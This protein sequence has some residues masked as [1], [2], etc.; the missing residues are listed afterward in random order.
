MSPAKRPPDDD[1]ALGALRELFAETDRAVA[2]LTC[3]ASTE[4]CRFGVTG[5]EPYVTALE[6]L[7]LERAIAARGGPLSPRRRALPLAPGRPDA[8]ERRC[9]FL[10]DRGRCVVYASR[11]FGCR[12]FFCERA[13]GAPDRRAV[14]ELGAR[15]GA[16]AA[17]HAPGGDATRPLSR[18]FPASDS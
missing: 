14:R 17:A 7:A 5:R 10:D 8:R 3:P 6:V 11:P 15:L 9:A 4:C 18:I 2:E 16:L 1:R 13:S 12:T